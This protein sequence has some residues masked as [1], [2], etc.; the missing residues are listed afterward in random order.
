MLVEP[1]VILV[2][3]SPSEHRRLRE[4][5]AGNCRGLEESAAPL[6]MI[7]ARAHETGRA[8]ALGLAANEAS[9]RML[10]QCQD[11]IGNRMTVAA[12]AFFEE[13]LRLH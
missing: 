7:V 4:I 11:A 3:V 9:E 8:A 1:G 13:L 12:E 5:I 6:Y 2:V 10:E